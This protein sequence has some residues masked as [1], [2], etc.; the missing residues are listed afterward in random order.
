V[1]TNVS[2]KRKLGTVSVVKCVDGVHSYAVCLPSD[3]E[4]REKCPVIFCFDPSGNGKLAVRKFVFSAEKYGFIIIGSLDAKNGP[5]ETILKAQSAM[6]KDIPKRYKADEKK[7][8]ATGFS[9]GA[10]MAYTIAYNNPLKFKGVIACGAGFG[11]GEISKDV[12]VY[13]CAGDADS[14][15]MSVVKRTHSEL[16]KKGVKSEIHVFSGGHNWPPDIVVEQALDWLM[17]N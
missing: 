15:G 17:V 3:Y 8:Y 12:A 13:H 10:C 16:Q 5:W 1:T 7:Y 9:G 2:V 6:L 14:A 11:K 4:K